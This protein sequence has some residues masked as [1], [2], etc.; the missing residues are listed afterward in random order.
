MKPRNVILVLLGV[1]VIGSLIISSLKDSARLTPTVS[2]PSQPSA[3]TS[4][5][6]PVPAATPDT[7]RVPHYF[8]TLADA[9]ELPQILP[10]EQFRIPIVARAY[11]AAA[12]IREVLAQQPCY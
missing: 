11:R 1:L 10:A 3:T 7:G 6:T 9:G 2:A 8:K 12:R 4:A 5:P